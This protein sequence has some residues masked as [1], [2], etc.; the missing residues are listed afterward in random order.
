MWQRFGGDPE[1]AAPAAVLRALHR[2]G[3][4]R[5]L[6]VTTSPSHVAL[7]V[8]TQ[9]DQR[10]TLVFATTPAIYSAEEDAMVIETPTV[11]EPQPQAIVRLAL[12]GQIVRRGRA[13][14]EE[15]RAGDAEREERHRGR[16]DDARD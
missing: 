4:G 15:V 8:A 2:R 11:N 6:R 7:T 5:L 13:A 12:D 10:C 3:V 9:S 1:D 14:A 16:D